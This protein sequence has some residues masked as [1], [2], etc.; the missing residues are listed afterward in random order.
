M[1]KDSV[2]G[3]LET[4]RREQILG[5]ATKV[6]AEKGF[7]A[8]KMQE[9]ADRAGV[10]NGTVY[11]YFSSKDELLLAL[12]EQLSERERRTEGMAEL[13]AGNLEEVILR[14]LRGRFRALL[15]QREL[16][17]VVLPEF[18]VNPELRRKGY[19]LIIGPTLELGEATFGALWGGGKPRG[20]QAAHTVRATAGSVL[21]VF[22]LILMGDEKTERESDAILATLARV[23]AA[24]FA[25]G[26][27]RAS[28]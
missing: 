27:D 19:N 21:G 22:V 1:A 2:G 8:A 17:Q 28:M 4:L 24:A 12:L 20:S 14:Q 23:F 5:A 15:E 13:Q 7:R 11:N 25:G 16:W 18:I 6:F 3:K 26:A 9:V 10:S